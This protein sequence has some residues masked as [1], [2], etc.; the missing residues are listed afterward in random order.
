MNQ[1]VKLVYFDGAKKQSLYATFFNYSS[2]WLR[3]K[4][5]VDVFMVSVLSITV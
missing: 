1:L 5:T 3:F 2:I 4:H